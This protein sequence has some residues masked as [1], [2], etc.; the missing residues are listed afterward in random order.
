MEHFTYKVYILLDKK[1]NIASVN[2]SDFLDNIE[3]W[4]L[5][6]EGVGDRY[7]HAQGNY[8]NG[9]IYTY[10]GIPLYCWDG[11]Q[12]LKRTEEEIEND[13]RETPPAPLDPNTET[14][15]AVV[16]LAQVVE[17]NNTANQLAIAELAEAI[18][19]GSK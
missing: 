12:V 18:L 14:Q 6:D 5:I 16:E 13:R 9:G 3:G 10:D 17:D 7:H 11:E 2:S 1:N 15:L 19:G 4:I 8:F